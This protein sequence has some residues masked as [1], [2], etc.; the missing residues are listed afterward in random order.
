MT[1]VLAGVVRNIKIVTAL[2][3][4]YVPDG[5]PGLK[6]LPLITYATGTLFK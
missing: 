4:R 6:I 3:E 2:G 5:N 1:L